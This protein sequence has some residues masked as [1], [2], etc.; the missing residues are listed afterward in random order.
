MAYSANTDTG[1]PRRA[2]A[3]YISGMINFIT[4]TCLVVQHTVLGSAR[5]VSLLQQQGLLLDAVYRQSP[6]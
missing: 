4:L 6:R 3:E 2:T 1:V 5:Q